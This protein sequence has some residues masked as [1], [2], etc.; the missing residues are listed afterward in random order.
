MGVQLGD[1]VDARKLSIDELQ[2]RTVAFDG[3]NIMYQFLSIIRGRDGQPLKDRQG[4]ITS[5]LSGLLYRNSNLMEQGVKIVYVFDG[6]PHKFKRTVLK[7]RQETRRAAKKEYEKAVEAGD[8]KKARRYGQQSVVATTDI[9]SEAKELL[10]LMGIPV[11]QAPGEGEAQTA[12][13][14]SKGDVWGAASQDFDSLLYGAPR[15]IRNLSITGRRKLPRKNVYIKIEPEMLELDKVKRDL[16]LDQSQ[17]IDLG[18]LVGTDYNPDGIKGIGPKTALKLIR[19]HGNLDEAIPYIKNAEFPHPVD[20][21]KELFLKPRT[22]SD[23]SLEWN[24]PDVAGLLGFLC[25]E[26]NFSQQRVMSAVE[27]MQKGMEQKGE[28]TTLDR[29]FG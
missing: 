26:H 18:I 4:R 22:T 8:E 3:N 6:T 2:G 5:H 13:M 23:F 27:K 17:L 29:F 11:V 19:Q 9:I 15:H 1:I 7:R 20:E 12:Y 16:G 21:I 28:K 25:A 14:A 24:K 10:S